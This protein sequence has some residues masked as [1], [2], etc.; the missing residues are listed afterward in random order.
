MR[1]RSDPFRV[2]LSELAIVAIFRLETRYWRFREVFED[3]ERAF[4]EDPSSYNM[5]R[6][7]AFPDRQ[8]YVAVT[9]AFPGCPKLRLLVEI[10]ADIVRVWAISVPSEPV[11]D[12]EIIQLFEDRPQQ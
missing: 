10:E 11:F 6:I 3:V 4:R 1:R 8:L 5:V 12:A 7:N 9:A 2:D